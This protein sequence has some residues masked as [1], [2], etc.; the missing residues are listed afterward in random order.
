L[1][2]PLVGRTGFTFALFRAKTSADLPMDLKRQATLIMVVEKY[3]LKGKMFSE[4]KKEKLVTVKVSE[5][6]YREL[7]KSKAA[8]ELQLEKRLSMDW[9]IRGLLDQAPE[10]KMKAKLQG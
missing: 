4:K 3:S 6:T 10:W 5:S 2:V 1:G 9:V 7:I 8:A